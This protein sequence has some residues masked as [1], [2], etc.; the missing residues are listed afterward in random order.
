M[1]QLKNI[2]NFIQSGKISYQP[3]RDDFDSLTKFQE[4]AK[5]ILYAKSQGWIHDVKYQTDYRHPGRLIRNIIVLGGLTFQGEQLLK[6]RIVGDGNAAFEEDI[7]ELKP[8]IAGIGVNLN[9]AYR[10]FKSKFKN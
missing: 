1:Q 3:E 4:I 7:I 6:S 8:N 2:L 9:A 10:W 5:R